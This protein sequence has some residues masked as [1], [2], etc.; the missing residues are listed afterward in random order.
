MEKKNLDWANLGF[1]YMQ[2]D[3]RYVSNY[4]DGKWD[5]GAIVTDAN[6][7]LA[8]VTIAPSSHLPSL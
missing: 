5:D 6:V 1:G 7:T 3:Y 8:S 2:T 4:K